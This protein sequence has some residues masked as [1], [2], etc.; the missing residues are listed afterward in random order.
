MLDH[1][2][3][4]VPLSWVNKEV[5]MGKEKSWESNKQ[6]QQCNDV[7]QVPENAGVTVV[8]VC[9]LVGLNRLSGDEFLFWVIKEFA[10]TE[11]GKTYR[12][13]KDGFEKI[14]R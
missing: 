9:C 4:K 13:N 3:F 1:V 7:K 6:Q 5:S 8:V 10:G 11:S 12:K 2:L 14:S